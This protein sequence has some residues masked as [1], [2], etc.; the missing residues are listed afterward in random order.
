MIGKSAPAFGAKNQKGQS[1]KLI[2]YIGKK[3]VLYFY[4]KDDTPGCTK[5]ACKFRDMH[6]EFAAK[7][8]VILG[9]SPDPAKS[10]EKFIEKFGL[11]FSLLCDE[12]HRISESYNCWVEKS[13][14]GKKYMGVERSSFLIGEDGKL[15]AVLRKVKPEEHIDELLKEI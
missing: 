15:L 11:P 6:K 14:Y 8:V 2:D 10:H 13:M 7:N 3:V 12:D 1:V 5:E 4:P 9:V